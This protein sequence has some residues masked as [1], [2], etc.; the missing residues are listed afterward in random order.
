MA[1]APQ[2][3]PQM[4]SVDVSFFCP[5]GCKV[6][7]IL[8]AQSEKSSSVLAGDQGALETFVTRDL[9]RTLVCTCGSIL[10]MTVRGSATVSP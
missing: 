10:S 4:Y 9:G 5:K 8:G 1:A 6:D 7:P 3:I 2:S